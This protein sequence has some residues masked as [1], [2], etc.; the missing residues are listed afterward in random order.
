M[1]PTVVCIS[2]SHR[3]DRRDTIERCVQP[4]VPQLEFFDAVSPSTVP[5]DILSRMKVMPK[6]GPDAKARKAACFASHVAVLRRALDDGT[7]PLIVLED[8][9]IVPEAMLTNDEMKKLPNDSVCLLGGCL[10]SRTLSPDALRAFRERASIITSQMTPGVNVID[11]GVYRVSSSAA[12]FVPTSAVAHKL[13]D[14]LVYIKPGTKG[15]LTHYDIHLDQ[16][17]VVTTL[18]FPS[19]F[20][21]S[22][23]AYASDIMTSQTAAFTREYLR[24]SPKI[25]GCKRK[26]G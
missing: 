20:E 18:W 4:H 6:A 7:F 15:A 26:L 21:S 14:D 9:L 8:D 16:S 12:Y 5:F 17:S 19:P 11:K 22:D 2:L 23:E 24:A 1:D 25:V 10:Q 13:L 3:H